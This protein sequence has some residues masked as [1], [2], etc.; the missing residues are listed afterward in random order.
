M[1]ADRCPR[2]DR[3]TCQRRALIPGSYKGNRA[4]WQRWREVDANCH[5]NRVDWRARALKYEEQI[6]EMSAKIRELEGAAMI[7]MAEMAKVYGL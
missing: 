2:C 7:G 6:K 3:A 5:A 1:T 4:G